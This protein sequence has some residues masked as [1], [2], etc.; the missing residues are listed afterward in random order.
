MQN[1]FKGVTYGFQYKM[2][3]VYAHFP[4]NA[5]IEDSGK[6][7]EIRN[8]LGEKRVR[9]VNMLPGQNISGFS[10]DPSALLAGE[11]L[12]YL[13]TC[14]LL[15]LLFALSMRLQGTSSLFVAVSNPDVHEGPS[16]CHERSEA[17]LLQGC[18]IGQQF[19]QNVHEPVLLCRG[20]LSL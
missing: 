3:L 8:F 10:K 4:I 7:I 17:L 5:N 13:S 1:L 11:E 19:E 16:I 12:P 14:K 15:I 18:R 20:K 9:V 6:L 2:R